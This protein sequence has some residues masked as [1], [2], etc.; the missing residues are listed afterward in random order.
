MA[1]IGQIMYWLSLPF[2]PKQVLFRVGSTNKKKWNDA[3]PN[4][5][6][7]KKGIA[8]AYIDARL[9]MERLDR[10][11]GAE[12][13][14][15]TYPHAGAKTCCDLSICLDG[16]WITKSDGAGDTDVEGAKGAFS[17]SFKRAAVNWG[18]GQYLYGLP[19]K[20]FV[21]N[22]YWGLTDKTIE[23]LRASLPAPPRPGTEDQLHGP[24]KISELK[25]KM[26]A[27]AGELYK[28]NDLTTFSQ[29][30]TKY[31][32]EISQCERDLPS[33]YYGIPNSDSQGLADRIADLEERLSTNIAAQ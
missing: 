29:I 20:W 28:A 13:W 27:L 31:D 14:Q 18:I 24:I 22:D 1:N 7:E 25:E 16:R 26:K 10:V 2:D 30:R 6:P 17:D 32:A 23:E 4:N 8:L 5:K 9:V 3:P 33:W 11:V 15:R 12:N 21:L 19:N